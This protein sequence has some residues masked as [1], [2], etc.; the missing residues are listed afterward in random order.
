MLAAGIAAG[1]DAATGGWETVNWFSTASLGVIVAGFA[2][3][4]A[5]RARSSART[6]R[7]QDDQSRGNR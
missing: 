7:R 2:I 5:R 6:P 4:N 1:L 3:W